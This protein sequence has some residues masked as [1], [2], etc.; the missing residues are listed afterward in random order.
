[1]PGGVLVAVRCL[2]QG[3]P[4][5]RWILV[6]GSVLAA[7]FAPEVPRCRGE[8]VLWAG[9]G[10]CFGV[11]GSLRAGV[12]VLARRGCVAVWQS[13]LREGTEEPFPAETCPCPHEPATVLAPGSFA[14][15]LSSRG[16]SEVP[17]P[18]ACVCLLDCAGDALGWVG[19]GDGSQGAAAVALPGSRGWFSAGW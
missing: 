10:L 6:R 17:L 7:P 8:P 5:L 9:S 4:G 19:S 18:P 12:A 11:P 14:T 16:G 13:P 3:L 15:R 2:A 1:M